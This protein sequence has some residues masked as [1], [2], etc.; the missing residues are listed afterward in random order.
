MQRLHIS[1]IDV[2]IVYP[3]RNDWFAILNMYTLK[4]LGVNNI[5][6]LCICIY[7]TTCEFYCC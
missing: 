5:D 4:N 2:I 7:D 6:L 3:L 1:D